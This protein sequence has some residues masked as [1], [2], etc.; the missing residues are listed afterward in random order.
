MLFGY[1]VALSGGGD[2]LAVG[3][4]DERGCSTTVNG[5]YQMTCPGTGAVYAFARAGASWSQQAYLKAREQ[6]PGDSMGMWIA[7]SGDG[8]TVA[9][10]AGDED[11]MTTGVDTVQ[12]GHSGIVD[13]D[14]DRS[15]GAAYVFGRVAG[16]WSEQ[17][18]FKASNTGVTDWFGQ[19]LA[20][21][22]DGATLAVSAPNED[23]AATGFDGKQDDDGAEQAG[24]V[25][26]FTRTRGRWAQQVYV[27][28]SN[29]G[30]FD[31]FGSALALDR[32]G[33][34]LV[35][36]ARNEDGGAGGVNGN[37]ADNSAVNAGAVYVF[38]R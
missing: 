7:I 8:T 31:E 23:S 11:S 35:V 32:N 22:G 14:D 15:S 10:G 9:A 20:L 12:R 25:Y 17:A 29:T 18:S 37:Q 33:R 30:A 21:S 6:D 3:A 24:A 28:A 4:F 38:E 2:V 34:I 1:S 26:V 36:G 19:R 27:K 5:A 16:G 13:A